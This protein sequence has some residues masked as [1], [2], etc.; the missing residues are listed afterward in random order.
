MKMDA[1]ADR[2]YVFSPKIPPVWRLT[3]DHPQKL[4]DI[5][6]VAYGID[7]RQTGVPFGS[8]EKIVTA[9]L[10]EA[11]N[12]STYVPPDTFRDRPPRLPNNDEYTLLSE[13]VPDYEKLLSSAELHFRTARSDTIIG[14]RV[15][16]WLYDKGITIPNFLRLEIERYRPIIPKRLRNSRS[17]KGPVET[18]SMQFSDSRDYMTTDQLAEFVHTLFTKTQGLPRV[19]FDYL[20][21]V[22][23]EQWRRKFSKMDTRS[24]V[25]SKRPGFREDPHAKFAVVIP[26]KKGRGR[27]QNRRHI[28]WTLIAILLNDHATRHKK[29]LRGKLA[30]S[31]LA[32]LSHRDIRYPGERSSE[33]FRLLNKTLFRRGWD[34]WLASYADKY[35]NGLPR[36]AK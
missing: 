20:V 5:L 18:E 19:D 8:T 23:E 21:D 36:L 25:C 30:T 28:Y 32:V 1:T 10:Y 3:L 14:R 15:I 9:V 11:S 7:P 35:F 31:L 34:G 4:A 26:G 16:E 12:R 33:A 6:L 22:S 13:L 24:L 17:S 2:A 27:I 29:M